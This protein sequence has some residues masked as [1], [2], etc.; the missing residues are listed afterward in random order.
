MIDEHGMVTLKE[1]AILLAI[2][3]GFFGLAFGGME[4]Y[5]LATG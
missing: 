5:R 3:I 4:L 2:L 1:V